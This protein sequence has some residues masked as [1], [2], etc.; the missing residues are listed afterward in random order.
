MSEDI[1]E[2]LKKPSQWL[3][4]AYM[5]ALAVALYVASIVLTLLT[6]AQALFS[7]LTG[8]DNVNLRALGK[9]LS[10]YVYQILKFL[11][12]NSGKKPFPFSPYPGTEEA[13]SKS[14]KKAAKKATGETSGAKKSAKKAAAPDNSAPQKEAEAD[15]PAA[16]NEAA[17]EKSATHNEAAIEMGDDDTKPEA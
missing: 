1:V 14:A 10:T 13:A 12:Y 16:D 8:K 11:T 9:D 15:K 5:I 2:N 7:L 4:I 3:R 17:P 6:I